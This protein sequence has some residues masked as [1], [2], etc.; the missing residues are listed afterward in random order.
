[1]VALGTL[2]SAFWIISAN[3]WMQTPAGFAA[4]DKGQFIAV[5]WWAVIFNPSFP[6]RFIHMAL[7]A[8]LTTAF[9]VGAVGAWHLLRDSANRAAQVMFSMAMWMEAVVAPAQIA[10]GDAH[11]LNTLEYQPA[12]IAAMEGDFD[13]LAGAPLILFGIP[14]MAQGHTDYAVEIPDAGSLILTHSLHGTVKGLNDFPAA[15]RPNAQILF[16]SF[17]LMVG[18]GFAMFGLGLWSLFE[19]WR[20]RLFDAKWML[21]AAVAMGP[22]GIVAVLAG[23][24]TTE[25]GRQPYTV[26]GLLRTADSVSPIDAAAVRG[27]L[28]A[29]VIVY[30]AVFGAGIFYTLRLMNKPPQS[31]ESELSADEPIRA[32]GIMPAPVLGIEGVQP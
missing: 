20:G 18:L 29:F 3:S 24:F 19:R 23:W 27:S 28:I 22:S 31:G 7:A 1:M 5:D 9:I 21:R 13:T 32:S 15:D 26:Y 8:Y 16:W 4:N 2:I 6:Y 30:F 14:N 17:R 11:G 25:V 10:A 12:K